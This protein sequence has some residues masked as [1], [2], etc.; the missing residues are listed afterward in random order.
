MVFLIMYGLPEICVEIFHYPKDYFRKYL[1]IR[2][3][4]SC[5]CTGIGIKNKKCYS[6]SQPEEGGEFFWDDAVLEDRDPICSS[7]W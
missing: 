1:V 3:N 2:K 5:V 6:I 7:E 4:N